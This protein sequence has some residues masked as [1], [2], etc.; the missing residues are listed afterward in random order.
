M[1]SP[2]LRELHHH[3]STPIYDDGLDSLVPSRGQIILRKPVGWF[4]A[5]TEGQRKGSP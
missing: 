3:C 2:A 1:L 5:Q 4:N